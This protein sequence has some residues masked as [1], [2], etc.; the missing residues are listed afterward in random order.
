MAGYSNAPEGLTERIESCVRANF[1]GSWPELGRLA[2]VPPSTIKNVK[3]GGDPRGKTLFKIA[4]ALGV[5]IDWLITGESLDHA[6]PRSS[7][8]V[9]AGADL[10]RRDMEAKAVIDSTRTE[11]SRVCSTPKL[12]GHTRRRRSR[13]A[14]AKAW[15]S[16]RILRVF[17]IP[18]LQTT[19]GIS[20]GNAFMFVRRLVRAG[21]LRI[22]KECEINHPGSRTVYRLVRDTGPRQP[23]PWNS[24]EVYDQ[25]TRG[26]ANG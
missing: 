10:A 23:I 21:Y 24:G 19:A 8:E 11:D 4:R 3:N 22:V 12:R 6:R 14:R 18:Q 15:N 20:E 1:R 25:N 2:G 5:S 9:E 17:T 13:D 7:S 26:V 16:I